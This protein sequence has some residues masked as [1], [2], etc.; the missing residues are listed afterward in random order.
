MGV[1]YVGPLNLCP[2]RGLGFLGLPSCDEGPPG[3]RQGEEGAPSDD[4]L[5][6]VRG[7]RRPGPGDTALGAGSPGGVFGTFNFLI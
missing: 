3:L 4:W 5:W 6:T 1:G 2:W 7:S